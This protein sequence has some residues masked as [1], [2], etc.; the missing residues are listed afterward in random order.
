VQELGNFG[1]KWLGLRGGIN[2]RHLMCS[3]GMK[4]VDI[5]ASLRDQADPDDQ[6]VPRCRG[7]IDPIQWFIG[8]LVIPGLLQAAAG[9]RWTEFSRAGLPPGGVRGEWSRLRPSGEEGAAT[10]IG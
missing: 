3:R 10:A 8:T 9:V 1:L 6:A 7:F 5:A 4:R 2:R